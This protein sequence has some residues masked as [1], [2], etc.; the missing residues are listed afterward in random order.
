MIDVGPFLPERGRYAAFMREFN[1]LKRA[2]IALRPM[3]GRGAPTEQ[4]GIGTARTART[5]TN[6]GGGGTTSGSTVRWG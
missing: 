1:R 6:E 2:I 5:G 4:T 3:P